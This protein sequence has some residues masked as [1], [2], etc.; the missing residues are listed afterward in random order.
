M[1]VDVVCVGTPFLDVIFRGLPVMPTAGEEVLASGVVIV[2]GAMA[3]VAFAMRQL[4]LEAV[5]CAPIGTDAAGRFLQQLMAEAGVPWIGDP[6]DATPVS[7]GL[8]LDGDR[9]FVTVMPS[10]V[11]DMSAVAALE[12]RAIVINLPLPDGLPVRPK[13]FGVLGDPQVEL[14]RDR[15]TDSLS[16]LRALIVNERE[17][18]NL[19]GQT[20]P[21]DAGRQIAA[22][23]CTVIV[24]RSERGALAAL[25]DG[26]VIEA[27]ADPAPAADTV[28]AGDL[29][30]AAFVLADLS[31]R[32]LEECLATATAYASHSLATPS[33]R[34]KGLSRIAF[35]D[36]IASTTGPEAWML[37]V[38]G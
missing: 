24:T 35:S 34:Q 15:P 7:V 13:T 8:P 6:T 36:A 2:P 21:H 9:A 32:S 5:V 26:R 18:C 10:A 19:T 27:A 3:N 33:S 38:R 4:G 17:A 11:I 22:R 20:E 14:M 37:E 12:P 23:G 29:F 31:D 1:T 28:G 25:P 16:S 30:A